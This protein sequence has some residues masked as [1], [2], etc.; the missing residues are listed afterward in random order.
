MQVIDSK[1]NLQNKS[2]DSVLTYFEAFLII[3]EILQISVVA[4]VHEYVQLAF[5]EDILPK[6][7]DVGVLEVFDDGALVELV[8]KLTWVAGVERDLLHH[9]GLAIFQISDLIDG[10]EGPFSQLRLDFEV[11]HLTRL[12]MS[13]SLRAHSIRTL[14]VL[15]HFDFSGFIYKIIKFYFSIN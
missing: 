2:F 3:N 15:T 7:A 5:L 6:S 1:Q 9:E 11:P 13:F 12:V 8:V 4:I 14:S 10:A